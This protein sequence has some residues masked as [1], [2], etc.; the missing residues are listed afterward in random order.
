MGSIP[1]DFVRG[2]F[3]TAVRIVTPVAILVLSFAAAVATWY[4][5]P[6]LGLDQGILASTVFFTSL[7]LF[8]TLGAALLSS[9]VPTRRRG[10]SSFGNDRSWHQRVWWWGIHTAAWLKPAVRALFA[11]PFAWLGALAGHGLGLEGWGIVVLIVLAGS[12]GVFLAG[13]IC[14]WLEQWLMR[15]RPPNPDEELLETFE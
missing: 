9:T 11:F 12:V 2:F 1:S 13:L 6:M 8:A 14:A 10:S 15:Y 4:G 3:R 7:P 5:A